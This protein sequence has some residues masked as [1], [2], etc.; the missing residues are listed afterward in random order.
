MQVRE[1]I[2]STM[3]EISRLATIPS[4][5][6]GHKVAVTIIDLT[7]QFE[8]ETVPQIAAH[9]YVTAKVCNTSSYALLAGPSNIFLDNNFIAKVTFLIRH[10]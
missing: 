2:V 6:V 4:D 3:Y 10:E 8:H 5:N 9:A 1:G 7:P